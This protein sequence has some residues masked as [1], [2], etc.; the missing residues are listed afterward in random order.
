MRDFNWFDELYCVVKEDGTFAGRPCLTLEEA[1]ELQAQHE[2]SKIFLLV[3]D[4]QN[5]A[6][7][8]VESDF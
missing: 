4:N 7:E 1:I 8:M 3:Y 2:G 5:F 6:N